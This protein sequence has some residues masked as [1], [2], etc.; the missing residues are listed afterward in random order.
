MQEQ[1]RVLCEFCACAK[2]RAARIFLLARS[3]PAFHFQPKMTPFCI[4]SNFTLDVITIDMGI[5]VF[6]FHFFVRLYIA[7]FCTVKGGGGGGGAG[8][9]KKKWCSVFGFFPVSPFLSFSLTFS[10]TKH[11]FEDENSVD[12]WLKPLILEEE[13]W[14]ATVVR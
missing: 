9:S 13:G 11:S 6:F 8:D 10:A 1:F 2:I 3:C 4:F 7:I 14:W 5:L 12:A